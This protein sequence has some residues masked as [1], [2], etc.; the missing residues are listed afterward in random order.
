VRVAARANGLRWLDWQPPPRYAAPARRTVAGSV[1]RV[2]GLAQP[3]INGYFTRTSQFRGAPAADGPRRG[4]TIAHH[5]QPAEA[6]AIE[7]GFG[8]VLDEQRAAGAQETIDRPQGAETRRRI[9]PRPSGPTQVPAQVSRRRHRKDGEG[10]GRHGGEYVAQIEPPGEQLI[11]VR[12][13]DEE[14]FGHLSITVNA[15]TLVGR[16]IRRNVRVPVT[17][18]GIVVR[19]RKAAPV[20]RAERVQ[21][22]TVVI[23]TV[24]E[25]LSPAECSKCQERGQNHYC[26]P[27]GRTRPSGAG[28][29]RW[30]T[31][32]TG[33]AH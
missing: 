20:G 4:G 31:M 23:V 25:D 15:I 1:I 19:G 26:Q 3:A 13:G 21:V 12:Q 32:A 24:H 2:I 17:V 28:K 5:H 29:Q 7:R 33:S 8:R 22:D 9:G 18:L 16:H 6:G 30:I 14:P 27:S 10:D 11:I